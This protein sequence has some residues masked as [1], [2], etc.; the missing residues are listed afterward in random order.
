MGLLRVSGLTS[1]C[2]RRIRQSRLWLF[3]M[4]ALIGG[5]VSCLLLTELVL[6]IAGYGQPAA[7]CVPTKLAGARRVLSNPGFANK[8]FGPELARAGIPFNLPAD[9]PQQDCR[10]L[11]LG[12]SAARGFPQPAFGMARQLEQLLLASEAAGAGTRFQV[13]N[14]AITAI[15]SHVVREIAWDCVRLEPDLLVVYLGNNEV[16]GPFGPGTVFSPLAGNRSLIHASLAVRSTR[17]GQLLHGLLRTAA[18]ARGGHTKQ[19]GGMEMFL[20]NQVPAGDPRLEIMYGHFAQNLRDICAAG[21]RSGAPVILCTVGVNERDCA[22]FASAH[23]PGFSESDQAPWAEQFQR[24]VA[25]QA[26]E[27]WAAALEAFDTAA[28]IDGQF[29]E[30]T[31]RR[32]IC[33]WHLEHFRRARDLF[34]RAR[35]Q[36]TLRFRADRRINSIIRSIAAELDHVHLVDIEQVLRQHSDRGVPGQSLFYEHVHLRFRGNYLVATSLL[37]KVG[38]VLPSCRAIAQPG[39]SII[40]ESEMKRGLAF[41]ALEER[42]SLETVLTVAGRPPFTSSFHRQ[43]RER[44]RDEL[45][46][47]RQHTS[48][49]ALAE[50]LSIHTSALDLDPADWTLRDRYASMLFRYAHDLPAAERQWRTVL[51]CVPHSHEVNHHL[52]VVLSAQRRPAEAL[53]LFERA[54]AATPYSPSV[55]LNYSRALVGCG[56]FER[57][58]TCLHRAGR[59]LPQ[60]AAVPAAWALLQTR[61]GSYDEA[62]ESYEQALQLNPGDPF[63]H[64]DLAQLLA[65]LGRTE[66]S[67]TRYLTAIEVAAGSGQQQLVQELKKRLAGMNQPDL[68]PHRQHDS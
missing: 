54:L 58:A 26:V 51:E 42:E 10:V 52:A 21:A 33:C 60:D 64:A 66:E 40:S 11:L 57:A 19:W 67:R 55:L 63:V 59:L 30:L 20:E 46:S 43:E 49:A 6:W 25:L 38:R 24:G 1:S 28:A 68:A 44:L 4:A 2:L 31:F 50:S 56:R 62:I 15:N 37:E 41:S 17:C 27:K 13:V 29:A 8:Y 14:T 3:R 23:R 53:G 5:P 22:P 32:A 34:A 48:G 36:D 16:V 45:R 35:D 12:G 61:Q 9:K 65:S 7:F 18:R 39:G 47:L